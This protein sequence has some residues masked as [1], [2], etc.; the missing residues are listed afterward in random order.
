MKRLLEYKKFALLPKEL[1]SKNLLYHSTYFDYFE[2]ILKENELAGSDMYDTGIA[3]SRNKHYAFGHG[4]GENDYKMHNQGDV[5]FILD[6]DKIKS[7]CKIKAF[8]WEE[9]KISP[10]KTGEW[11]DYHQA[12]DK[13]YCKNNT[14]K[15]LDKYV[16]GIHVIK[17]EYLDKVLKN[18]LINDN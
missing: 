6:R 15:E 14:L 17:N 16:I 12:E 5:Q 2:R 9:M 4:D 7:V 18:P 11:N 1:R 13:V 8:D 10:S 3:T